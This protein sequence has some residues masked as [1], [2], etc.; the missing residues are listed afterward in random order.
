MLNYFKKGIKVKI[1][2]SNDD[3]VYSDGLWILAKEVSKVA[4]VVIVAPDREQSAVGTAVSLR[5]PL[6]VQKIIPLEPGI[7]AYSVEGTPS[8]SVIVGLG[9]LIPGKIDIVISGINQGSNMGEDVLI[10]GTVGAALAAYLRGFPSIAISVAF[11][12]W[13]LPFLQDTSR[14]TARLAKRLGAASLQGNVLLNVNMPGVALAE[15]KDV[16]ITS[17][18]HKSHVNTVEEGHDGRRS[19]YMLIRE[20]VNHQADPRSDIRA[21][22]QDNISI[23]PLH[24]FLNDRLNK[25]WLQKLTD[26]LLEEAKTSIPKC[27]NG[28]E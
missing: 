14:F 15:V 18:A 17:L 2:I 21:N 28:I 3:G 5:K 20:S 6:R 11:E 7:E 1:L 4:E 26:G 10:S 8:D 12:N 22:M 13:N 16:K 9:K 23:T 24:L 27:K 19:Y 25:N